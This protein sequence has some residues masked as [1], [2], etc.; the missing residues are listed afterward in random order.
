MDR[1]WIN[2]E[3][4][5]EGLE[6]VWGGIWEDLGALGQIFGISKDFERA[7]TYLDMR[8]PRWS[9]K[10]HNARGSCTPR[11]LD[12]LDT[13]PSQF[14]PWEGLRPSGGGY[15]EGAALLVSLLWGGVLRHFFSIFS[16]VF[17]FLGASQIIMA[18]FCAFFRFSID[19]GW[20]WGGFGEGF[21]GFC[22][23]FNKIFRIFFAF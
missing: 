13:K 9:A 1:F 4:F 17:R 2:F 8:P 11:V 6:R 23:G 19:F 22:K 16:H 10:R 5:G 18:F 21:G 12:V 14:L 3:G 20:I 15:A 7:G